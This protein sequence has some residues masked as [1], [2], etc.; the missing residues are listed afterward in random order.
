[1]LAVCRNALHVARSGLNTGRKNT[2]VPE[3]T[4]STAVGFQTRTETKQRPRT[5][6]Y[7]PDHHLEC[8]H[9]V[10]NVQRINNELPRR[11]LRIVLT[12]P[13]VTRWNPQIT[14]GQ[15]LNTVHLKGFSTAPPK[16]DLNED[17]K[18]LTHEPNQCAFSSSSSYNQGQLKELVNKV[19]YFFIFNSFLLFCNIF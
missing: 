17:Q 2:K 9:H 5:T 4:R 16:P 10:R 12:R 8:A 11:I 1:M 18:T 6:V 3:F 13:H 7:H 14:V 19:V 15:V